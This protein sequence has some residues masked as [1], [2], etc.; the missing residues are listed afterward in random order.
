[1]KLQQNDMP[2]IHRTCDFWFRFYQR[3]RVLLSS[4]VATC[5]R[6]SLSLL[7]TP[8]LLR[9]RDLWATAD[10]ELVLD[11]KSPAIDAFLT[12]RPPCA[13]SHTADGT[14]VKP[15]SSTAPGH[16]TLQ[17]TGPLVLKQHFP[18]QCLEAHMHNELLSLAQ[19]HMPWSSHPEVV[20]QDEK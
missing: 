10:L 20:G 5:I 18:P 15:S 3:C 12:T 6:T 16:R 13:Q 14:R 9:K 7:P 11:L 17:H 4:V 1:M 2:Q 8:L 19:A